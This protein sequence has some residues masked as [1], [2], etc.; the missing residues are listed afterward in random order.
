MT[1][2]VDP[3][4]FKSA[5]PQCVKANLPSFESEKALREFTKANC[6]RDGYSYVWNC[7]HCLGWHFHSLPATAKTK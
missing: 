1:P 3:P 5:P 6:P 2:A 4:R 7:R